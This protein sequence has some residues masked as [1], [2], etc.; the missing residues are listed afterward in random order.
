VSFDFVEDYSAPRVELIRWDGAQP[1][2][3]ITVPS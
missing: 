2:T 3:L 1:A